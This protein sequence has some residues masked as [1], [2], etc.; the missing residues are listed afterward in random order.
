[1]SRESSP[2]QIAGRLAD[3]IAAVTVLAAH[4]ESEME[5]AGWARQLSKASSV[6]ASQVDIDRWTS[7]FR[8]HP[9]FFMVYALAPGG[10]DKAA[11]RLRYANKTIDRRTGKEPPNLRRLPPAR[12]YDLTSLP[13]DAAAV[14]NLVS[15]AIN[16]HAV[17]M[18]RSADARFWVQPL[19]GLA[20]VALGALLAALLPLLTPRPPE[21]PTGG[22][23]P[24]AVAA[25]P[26]A[27]GPS[28]P[29]HR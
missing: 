26:T 16:M 28:V 3:V 19:I 22:C 11:L 14:N 21:R 2:Y 17:A 23:S 10:P 1:M 15:A 12:R 5:I 27:P 7:V 9:E 24:P 13:L 4:R 20:G 6:P 8:D 18:A 25:C 29:P